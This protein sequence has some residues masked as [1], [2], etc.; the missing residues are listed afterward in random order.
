MAVKT[1]LRYLKETINF[2]IK[3]DPKSIDLVGYSDADWA[4]DLDTRKSTTG[5]LFKLGSVPICWKSK[6]QPIVALSTAEA[7][8]MALSMAAQTAIWIRK[9]LKDFIVAS[10]EPTVIYEDNQGCI[11]MAKNPVNHE[12]TKHIDIRYNFVRERVE[13]KTIS[14]KYMETT[15]MLADILTKGL[16]RDQHSKLCEEIGI[17]DC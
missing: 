9:L 5:Y 11:A 14:V 15:D 12:R 6:R 8:Y 4:G 17:M 1:I 10:K 16:P 13:D 3:C 2:G 7:E